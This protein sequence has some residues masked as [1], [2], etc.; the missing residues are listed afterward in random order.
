MARDGQAPQA[1]QLYEQVIRQHRDDPVRAQALLGFARLHVDPA[2]GLRDLRAAETAF[3]RLLADYP[4]SPGAGEAR[5]WRA[6]LQELA[7]REA[8]GARTRAD[9]DRLKADIDRVRSDLDRS[10]AETE[11]AR[12]ER[13]RLRT[14]LERL[15]RLDMELERRR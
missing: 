15:K 9:L 7:A 5:A 3:Q 8:E 13:E 11:Q 2:S 12:V 10:R 6:V 14:D 1:R 4:Q